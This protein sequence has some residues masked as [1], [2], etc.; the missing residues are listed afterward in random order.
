MHLAISAA[1]AISGA[2]VLIM[3]GALN[4]LFRGD[5][6]VSTGPLDQILAQVQTPN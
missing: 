6:R 3:I 1:M 5:F 4:N 2:L